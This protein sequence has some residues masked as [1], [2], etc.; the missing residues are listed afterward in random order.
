MRRK[1]LGAHCS[2]AE[3]VA[4]CISSNPE[5]RDLIARGARLAEGLDAELYVLHVATERDRDPIRKKTLDSHLQFATN[6][7]ATVASL[8]GSS[9]ASA[10]AAYVTEHRITQVLFGR[11]ALHGL[12]K[13]LYF[14]AMQKFIS[15]APHADVHIITQETQ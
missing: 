10:T 6:L 9:V 3:K 5:A 8:T 11:S 1:R 7:G 12:K 4:V 2:V 13:F 15:E 14:L